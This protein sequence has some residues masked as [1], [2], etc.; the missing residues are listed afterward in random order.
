M[1]GRDSLT[2]QLFILSLAR[3]RRD[4]VI[5]GGTSAGFYGMHFRSQLECDKF[6]LLALGLG[7]AR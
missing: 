3:T 5:V 1:V 2:F 6:I 4:D 7:A